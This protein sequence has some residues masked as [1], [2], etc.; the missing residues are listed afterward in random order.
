MAIVCAACR[1]WVGVTVN[2]EAQSVRCGECGHEEPIRLLPL[3][4]VTGTSGVGKTAVIAELRRLL[5]EWEVFDTDILWDSGGNYQRVKCNWLRIAY[6]IAQSGRPTILCGTILPS[7]LA[8]CDHLPFFRRI[9]YAALHCDD[10]SRAARLRARPGVL[11]CSEAFIA[12]HHRFAR[13][14]VENAETAFDPPLTLLDTT[15]TTVEE[16]AHQLR[17]WDTSY[18]QAIQEN[19]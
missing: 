13:W 9:H 17:D 1:H 12:E 2:Q 7:D 8:S 5:P 4:I 10:D 15:H 18:Y 19:R 3:F 16:T 6:S 14:F 11:A